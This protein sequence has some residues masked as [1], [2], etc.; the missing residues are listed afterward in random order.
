MY[1]RRKEELLYIEL[2]Q[3][4]SLYSVVLL[5]TQLYYVFMNR[6]GIKVKC[7]FS[8]L[9]FLIFFNF[10]IIYFVKHF[11]ILEFWCICVWG[12]VQ[13]CLFLTWEKKKLCPDVFFS[14]KVSTNIILLYSF[15]ALSFPLLMSK[16]KMNYYCCSAAS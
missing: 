8:F 16:I 14:F 10:S 1:V 12:Q 2:S 13:Q 4:D 7:W 9:P 11:P 15:S 5:W 6:I 3:N